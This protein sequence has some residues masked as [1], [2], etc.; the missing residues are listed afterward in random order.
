MPRRGTWVKM[1]EGRL[2][3]DRRGVRGRPSIHGMPFA[4]RAVVLADIGDPSA[5]ANWR[6][7]ADREN[8]HWS[9]RLFVQIRGTCCCLPVASHGAHV[10]RPSGIFLAVT[11]MRVRRMAYAP[12]GGDQ[13]LPSRSP[14]GP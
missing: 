14:G 12:V 2:P 9:L 10:M 11:M 13:A 3:S 7:Y 4:S 5:S 6:Q 1:G 8:T